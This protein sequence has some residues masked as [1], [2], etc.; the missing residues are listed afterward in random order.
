MFFALLSAIYTIAVTS[1]TYIG[2]DKWGLMSYLPLSFWIGL[3]SLFLLFLCGRKSPVCMASAFALVIIY[4]YGIPIFVEQN[5]RVINQYYPSSE[6]VLIAAR[7]QLITTPVDALITYHHMP[8][9]LYLVAVTS[10]ITNMNLLCMMKYIPLLFVSLNASLVFLTLRTQFDITR[11]F[12]GAIWFLSSFGF[13]NHYVLTPQGLS[14][15]LFLVFFFVLTKQHFQSEW[16]GIHNRRSRNL[17]IVLLTVFVVSTFT[18]LLSATLIL[19]G[20]ILMSVP[21]SFNRRIISYRFV[22][23]LMSVFLA[24]LIYNA[25]PF[26]DVATQEVLELPENLFTFL[27][28][29]LTRTQIQGSIFQILTLNL[30]FIVVGINVVVSVLGIS[31][32]IIRRNW[33]KDV[34]WLVWLIGISLLIGVTTYGVS[35][36][37]VRAFLFGLVF[38]SFFCIKFLWSKTAILYIALIILI[39]L[40][41]PAHYGSESIEIVKTTDLLGATFFA[42]HIPIDATYFC[43][44]PSQWLVLHIDTEHVHSRLRNVFDVTTVDAFSYTTED[45]YLLVRKSDFVVSSNL[46]ENLFMWYRGYNPLHDINLASRNRIYVNGDFSIYGN[47]SR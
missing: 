23:C 39:F 29:Q 42:K 19:I 46:E 20:I 47:L 24:Y 33:K 18:H 12:Q 25:Q 14:F 7:G 17:L 10:I 40:A 38:F 4:L 1:I 11:S 9:L 22:L 45:I 16:S 8:G 32:S 36:M 43:G 6:G 27:S 34:Y 15:A 31:L 30:R 13:L 28:K 37:I 5:P 35:E 26:V 44:R 41:I 3:F 21:L 2:S